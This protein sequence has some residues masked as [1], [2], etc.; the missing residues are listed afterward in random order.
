MLT[1]STIPTSTPRSPQAGLPT[2]FAASFGS[3]HPEADQ[4]SQGGQASKPSGGAIPRMRRPMSR[5]SAGP[6][7]F[8]VA[9]ITL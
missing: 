5:A 2:A 8:A 6:V 3:S 4:V 1:L 9:S 7:P